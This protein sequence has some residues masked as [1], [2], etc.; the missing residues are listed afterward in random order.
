M[1][2]KS[3]LQMQVFKLNKPKPEAHAAE[4][5]SAEC[6]GIL[7]ELNKLNHAR[8]GAAEL[9]IWQNLPLCPQLELASYLMN[10]CNFSRRFGAIA[11]VTTP[12]CSFCTWP[13]K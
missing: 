7:N 11:S 13:D 3:A 12:G 5:L 1:T 4:C 8:D 9:M 2:P 6:C 10:P